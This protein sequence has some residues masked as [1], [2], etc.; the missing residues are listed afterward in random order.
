MKTVSKELPLPVTGAQYLIDGIVYEVIE[1][2]DELV[3]LSTLTHLRVICIA[4]GS[5]MSDLKRRNITLF[6]DQPGR[7]SSAIAFLFPDDPK[8]IEAKR[9]F[10]YIGTV[11]KE[12]R[13]RLPM[14]A[15][16]AII[17]Q[18]AGETQDLHPPGYSTLCRWIARFRANG[19]D[20]FS[21]YKRPSTMPR[22]RKL[23]AEIQA[24][25]KALVDEEYMTRDERITVQRVYQLLDG[26]VL[27]LNRQRAA[28]LQPLLR[29]PCRSTVV[30]A[31]AKRSG[32]T[33][34][35]AHLGAEAAYKR[36]QFSGEQDRPSAP[37]EVC[38]IDSHLWDINVVDKQH[39]V[40]GK[41]VHL[42]AIVDL[43]SEMVIGWEL[44]L[45]YP[46]AEKTLKA[47]RM[48]VEAVPGEEYQR[49]A[50]ILLVSDGGS[51]TQNS[52]VATVLDRLGIKW[53]LPPP[54]SPNTRPRIERFFRTFESW[55]HE[56][57]GTTFSN[58]D[59]CR[60]YDS[61]RHACYTIEN[62]VDY[63]REWLEDVYHNTKHGTLHMPPRVAWERAMQNQLPPR[64]FSSEALDQLFRGIEYSALSG[65]RAA[66]FSLTWT[67]PGLRAVKAK[68]H[69][70]QNAICYYDP[71]DLGVIWVAAPDSPRDLVPA[72]G[73]KRT[74]QEGLTLS[75]HRQVQAKLTADGKEFDDG[76]AH[77]AL[78]HLRQRM[79]V[80]HDTFMANKP[81]LIRH[82]QESPDAASPCLEPTDFEEPWDEDITGPWRVD[83]A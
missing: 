54:A 2:D 15:T 45:T 30:R 43:Y 66:F 65:N 44:S 46:C 71:S 78:L 16:K 22:G 11:L 41:I 18:I 61:A 29:R 79:S 82:K 51:E 23:A 48:A 39:N 10:R 80:D 1:I 6:A 64:K 62:L 37:L 58:P 70:N 26:H 74:Y 72:S 57:Y 52:L 8:V 24:K 4:L 40:L 56:Q 31:I 59:A 33:S 38:E 60:D 12:L 73:T 55:L 14:E 68:L 5:F 32:Y 76:V 3:T 34:D 63:F 7:G 49:G 21:L 67:G 27:Q 53:T 75:E 20:E 83:G 42:T 9:K 28:A 69:K 36:H 35:R 47:L 81:K 17:Q 50:M 25:L 19:S 77:L 13:N